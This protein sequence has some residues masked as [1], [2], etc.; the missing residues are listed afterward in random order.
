MLHGPALIGAPWHFAVLFG[1]PALALREQWQAGHLPLR[2]RKSPACYAE[3]W[4]VDPRRTPTNFAGGAQL[5][6]VRGKSS[7]KEREQPMSLPAMR[8]GRRT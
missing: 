4:P 1:L 3:L 2:R 5:L 6:A 8:D 7:H